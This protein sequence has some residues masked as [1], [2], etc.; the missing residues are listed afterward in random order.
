MEGET[1]H[2]NAEQG[3]SCYENEKYNTVSD[4]VPASRLKV[5]D[6]ESY[7]KFCG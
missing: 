7:V 3:G 2:R 5:S 1:I 6:D 4:E